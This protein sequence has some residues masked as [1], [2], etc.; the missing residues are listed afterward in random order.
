MHV[1]TLHTQFDDSGSSIPRISGENS[2]ET[3]CFLPEPARKCQEF[4][5]RIRWPYPAAGFDR[6]LSVPS[7]T[8]HIRSL[9][10]FTGILLPWNLR[11]TTEP[12]V[13]C[14]TASTWAGFSLCVKKKIW[15]FLQRKTV[16]KQSIYISNWWY[17][18]RHNK[19]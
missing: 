1:E 14:C 9:D 6:F 19:Q 7:E 11:N 13:S 8:G 2:Q 18:V 12:A 16:Y 5:T 17:F 3:P 15:F 10:P 4:D